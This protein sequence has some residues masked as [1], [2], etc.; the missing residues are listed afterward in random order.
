[1]DFDRY[2]GRFNKARY[3]LDMLREERRD[4]LITLDMI[5]RRLGGK[6]T[7]YLVLKY[8]NMGCPY[9]KRHLPPFERRA[10]C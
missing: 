3:K 5:K 10:G 1:M 4:V 2:S 8:V 6:A 9:G 7:K